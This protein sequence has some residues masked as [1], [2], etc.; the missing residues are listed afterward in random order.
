MKSKIII[1]H[2]F[3]PIPDRKYDW[4]AFRE[5][6]EEGHLIGYG[7]TK[8][9]A[10]NNLLEQEKESNNMGVIDL[11]QDLFDFFRRE[12][13]LI[14]TK[15]EMDDIIYESQRF[16]EKYNSSMDEHSKENF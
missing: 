14:L 16:I 2:E 3:P 5:D 4:S 12:H 6:Y 1:T 8:L 11:Y 13:D 7:I 10:I 15:G 9:E